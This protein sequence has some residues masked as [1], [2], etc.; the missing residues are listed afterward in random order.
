MRRELRVTSPMMRS[1]LNWRRAATGPGQ[2]LADWARPD[3]C[4]PRRRCTHHR[5]DPR[6]SPGTTSR[7]RRRRRPW[8]A[9]LASALA[10]AVR[11]GGLLFAARYATQTRPNGSSGS[12]CSACI[13]RPGRCGGWSN[14]AYRLRD[15]SIDASWLSNPVANLLLRPSHCPVAWVMVVDLSAAGAPLETAAVL[16]GLP[17]PPVSQ[18]EPA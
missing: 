11:L 13:A 18:V 12:G 9:L 1:S 4:R 8:T 17:M 16:R 2:Q 5:A 10:R 7:S 14:G 3:W 6:P 15:R